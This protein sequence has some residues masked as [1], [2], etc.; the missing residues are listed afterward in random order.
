MFVIGSIQA[1]V[2]RKKSVGRCNCV[3]FTHV[4]KVALVSSNIVSARL[5]VLLIMFKSCLYI[6]TWAVPCP[7][8]GCA[9]KQWYR[10]PIPCNLCPRITFNILIHSLGQFHNVWYLIATSEMV[11][12]AHLVHLRPVASP[13]PLPVRG[14]TSQY[15]VCV[16]LYRTPFQARRSCE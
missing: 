9:W 4:S 15:R 6:H 12:A 1:K 3:S 7:L 11:I 5:A 2:M 10:L 8:Y 14:K 16:S 13:A